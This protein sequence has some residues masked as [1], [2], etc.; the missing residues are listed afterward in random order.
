MRQEQPLHRDA[1]RAVGGN[2]SAAQAQFAYRAYGL[3]IRSD[4]ALPELEPDNADA[5]DIAIRLQKVAWPSPEIPG[6]AVIDLS[7]DTQ[8]LNWARVGRFAIRAAREINIEPA[9]DVS[10]ALLRLPLLGPVTAL[11]LY[12]RGHFVLHASAVSVGG[13]GAIFVGDKQ[14]GKSTTAAVMVASGHRLLADDVVAIDVSA[15]GAPSILPGFPQLKLDRDAAIDGIPE[16]SEPLPLVQPNF[17]KLQH[18]LVGRFSHAPAPPTRVYVLT[19]GTNIAATPLSPSE[20][21]AALM[22]FS[23]VTRFG[24]DALKEGRAAEH[25]ERCAALASAAQVSRLTVPGKV[26]RLSEVVQLV[27]RDLA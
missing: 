19:R 1:D 7:A 26:D 20:A 4:I 11:L 10:E 2:M 3:G 8:Y 21:L 16:R 14:A 25:F 6:G 13:K 22:R 27:E 23:Y 15:R 12:L 18:R 9:P 5:D 17:I 24:T